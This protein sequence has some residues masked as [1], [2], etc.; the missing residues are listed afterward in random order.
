MAAPS[1]GLQPPSPPPPA[2]KKKQV[3]ATLVTIVSLVFLLLA[4]VG[5]YKLGDHTELAWLLAA[6]CMAG[7]LMFLGSQISGNV[8]G[9]LISERNLMSLSRFQLVAWT[10]LLLSAFLVA[11]LHRLFTGAAQNALNIGIDPTLWG[12]MGISA[13]SFVG[14]PLLL[15][16]KT[17]QTLDDKTAK[18]TSDDL[19]AQGT[20]ESVADIQKNSLGKLYANSKM[21]DARLTDLFQGDEVGN[22]A[23]IDVSKVQMFFFTIVSLLVYGVSLY[24]VMGSAM[25][26]GEFT[27]GALS[28]PAPS[29]AMLGLL[30]ISHATYLT[31]KTVPKN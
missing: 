1:V 9:A 3:S 29:Q 31:S 17:T 7:Y 24:Y 5:V 10:I 23:R 18:K 14:S 11:V 25:L 12:L 26:K 27:K 20:P 13:A 15:N 8:L 19:A 4:T 22:T 28:F 6:A 2:E 21:S 30:G 16:S